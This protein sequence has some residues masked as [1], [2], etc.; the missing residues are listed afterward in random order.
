MVTLLLVFL[1]SFPVGLSLAYLLRKKVGFSSL[2]I[3]SAGFGPVVYGILLYWLLLVLPG[4]T[5]AFYLGALAI[6]MLIVSVFS[7]RYWINRD[8]YKPLFE[9]PTR[10]PLAIV[11]LVVVALSWLSFQNQT[12][13]N[14]YFKSYI[15][16]PIVG[17]DFTGY[18]V[19]GEI[20]YRDKSLEAKYDKLD[21]VSGY[22]S[23][24]NHMPVFA[25]LHTLDRMIV[26]VSGETRVANKELLIRL[27]S[28][29]Y[30]VLTVLLLLWTLSHVSATLA[31]VTVFGFV[32]GWVFVQSVTLYHIDMIR[33]YFV[34]YSFVVMCWLLYDNKLKHLSNNHFFIFILL[35]SSSLHT[36]NFVI[37]LGAILIILR[38]ARKEF[39]SRKCAL[40]YGISFF[41]MG[42][43]YL[44]DIFN[45]NSQV[46]A[47][48]IR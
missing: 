36:L 18:V 41:V 19:E 4:Q 14:T 47:W 25:L 42:W 38:Y 34:L 46:V 43:H 20:Y 33:I 35:L 45:G 48:I 12:A 31:M 6:P 1:S 15:E 40:S 13:F 30:A 26:D 22:A 44:I 21:D 8:T 29:I 16:R 10:K 17:G 11:M 9:L 39:T 5:S 3:L 7:A 37:S 32:S 27:V 2:L 28:P 24:S 23:F